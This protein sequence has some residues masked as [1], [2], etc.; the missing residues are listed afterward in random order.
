MRKAMI[1]AMKYWIVEANIDGYRC[2]AADMIP[3]DFWQNAISQLRAMQT[4]RTVLMLAEGTNV[5]NFSAGF[6]MDYAWNFCDVLVDLYSGNKTVANLY[7]SNK[8][9]YDAIPQGKHKLRHITNHDKTSENSPITLFKNQKGAMSAFVIACTMGGSPLIYS[10]QEIGYP[11]KISIFNPV[12]IDWNLN[13]SVYSEYTKLM[14]IYSSSTALQKGQIQTYD[15]TDIV[16]F[17]RLDGT[18]GVYVAVNVRNSAKTLNVPSQFAGT[19]MKDLVTGSSIT[20]A[21][22]INMEPYQYLILEK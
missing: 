2:D 17:Y 7:T 12:S 16:N 3:S 21:A 8:N 15:N 11:N 20:V 13:P 9:E 6:D 5:Q 1:D 22:T 4:N 10:T 14:Q 19:V 18:N